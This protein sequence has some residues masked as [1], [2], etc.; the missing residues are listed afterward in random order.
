[1]NPAKQIVKAIFG[2]EYNTWCKCHYCGE[3]G[4]IGMNCEKHHLRKKDTTR[5]CFMCTELGH[6]AKTYMN[7]ARIEDE[8]KAKVDNIRKYMRQQW[9]PKSTENT[10]PRNDD[11]FTQEL[12]DSTIST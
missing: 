10:I 7:T 9:V 6:F 2:W 12:G 11:Q 4:H 3:F 1:M 8:K 5:R